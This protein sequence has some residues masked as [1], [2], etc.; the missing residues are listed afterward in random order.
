MDW[1]NYASG[2]VHFMK[3][4]NDSGSMNSED[5]EK[6]LKRQPVRPVPG[7]WRAE[8]LRAANASIPAPKTPRPTPSLLSTI[9]SQ[10]SALLWPHPRA[11]AGL[12]A[13]WVV[14]FA[15]HHLSM[16]QPDIMAAMPPPSPQMI[17]IAREERRMLVQTI[18]SYEES[19]A[20]PPKPFVPRP[21]GELR[22]FVSMA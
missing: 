19:P 9:N 7:D 12:A 21:R 20:E 4:S 18:E 6:Q 8:I 3:K 2:C 5:F 16:D 14:I 10:L 13:V 15:F 11:W 17:R 22:A 1:T